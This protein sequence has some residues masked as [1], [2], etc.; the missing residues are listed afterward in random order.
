MATG[1]LAGGICYETAALAT[2]AYFSGLP[3]S[4]ALFPSG[5]LLS[6]QYLKDVSGLWNIRQVSTDSLGVQT[7]VYQ[8]VVSPPLFSACYSPS[9]SFADG[10][11]I[12]WAVSAMLVIVLFVRV[13]KQLMAA[14]V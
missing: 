9:E 6:T 11:T 10:V 14:Y 5:V 13:C 1:S 12:G 4:S 3:A 8:S 2:D 7:I